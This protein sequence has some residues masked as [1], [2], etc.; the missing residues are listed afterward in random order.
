MSAKVTNVMS[1]VRKELREFFSVTP[2]IVLGTGTSCAV[3]VG[4]G[5]GALQTALQKGVDERSLK[6]TSA[7]QWQ[8]V[9]QN[10]RKGLDLESSLNAAEA[11]D[12]QKLI[13]GITCETVA[14]MD[15]KYASAI[16]L[17]REKWPAMAIVQKVFEGV[18]SAD[19]NTL[20]VITTNYDLLLEYA[21]VANR[22]TCVDGYCGCVVRH[23]DWDATLRGLKHK[24]SRVVNKKKV[25]GNEFKKH[26]RLYKVH[27]SLNWFMMGEDVIE[28]DMWVDRGDV[29]LERVMITPG[30]AKYKRMQDFRTELQTDTDVAV[31]R[32]KA[33]LFLGYGMN[34][35]HVERYI[36]KRIGEEGVPALIVTREWN[37][38]IEK[39]ARKNSCVTVVCGMDN[40]LEGS[41]VFSPHKKDW[42][43]IPG[44]CLWDFS[45]FAKQMM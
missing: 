27:G 24:V 1:Q 41:R 30:L 10:L 42:Q 35:A 19:E 8:R 13:L 23:R 38:R 16:C 36:V 17:G 11:D 21:C 28:N 6:K 31:N 34:D 43:E 33:F 44:K 39:L 18:S 26:I 5:M 15:Q 37:K 7:R 25:E 14:A 45:E 4:F 2:H 3:D 12:L 22:I 32:A 20:E 40:P 9:L 29:G